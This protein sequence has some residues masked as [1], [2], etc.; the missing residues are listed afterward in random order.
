ML[1]YLDH[2]AAGVPLDGPQLLV[3][4]LNKKDNKSISFNKGPGLQEK[5]ILFEAFKKITKIDPKNM[6]TKIEGGGGVVRP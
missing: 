5:I 2:E 3:F 1:N 6:A 4:Y